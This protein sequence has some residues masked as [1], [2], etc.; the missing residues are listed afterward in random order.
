MADVFWAKTG[1]THTP[2]RTFLP[3]DWRRC[4]GQKS[5]G[6]ESPCICGDG[7]AYGLKKKNRE[8]PCR[9]SG[10]C[11]CNALP[12]TNNPDPT[13]HSGRRLPRKPGWSLQTVAITFAI[14]TWAPATLLEGR[15]HRTEACF[16]V[17]Q[18]RG[19]SGILLLALPALRVQSSLVHRSLPIQSFPAASRLLGP[20]HS[21]SELQCYAAMMPWMSCI[22]SS[23]L[24]QCF[25]RCRFERC[26]D[27]MAPP[28]FYGI[29]G[30][31]LRDIARYESVTL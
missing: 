25:E 16:S 17:G 2:D 19:R 28:Q 12:T 6:R 7:F 9:W 26:L 8:R 1:S 21:L 3:A 4:D 24:P 14:Q 27:W 29:S 15:V 18:C 23:A 13:L 20:D 31:R 22:R 10:K 5:L 30:V 11:C